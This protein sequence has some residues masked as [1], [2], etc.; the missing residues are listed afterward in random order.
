MRSCITARENA[1]KGI[2]EELQEEEERTKECDDAIA[3]LEAAIPEGKE[4][5]KMREE[6]LAN[7]L[8]IQTRVK[9]RVVLSNSSSLSR[10]SRS[11]ALQRLRSQITGPA[12]IISGSLDDQLKEV[13][14]EVEQIGGSIAELEQ[15]LDKWWYLRSLST[16]TTEYLTMMKA[17]EE[18]SLKKAQF[19]DIPKREK[20]EESLKKAQSDKIPKRSSDS[21]S[22]VPDSIWAKIFKL[23]LDTEYHDY[24]KSTSTTP[25][26][27]LVYVISHVCRSWRSIV[28]DTAELWTM[29][30]TSPLSSWKEH[31]NTLLTLAIQKSR[32]PITV[33]S[34]LSQATCKHSQPASILNGDNL[35]SGKLY[36]L[37]IAMMDDHEAYIKN[38][39]NLQ[40]HQANSLILSASE[41][42]K[43]GYF[44]YTVCAHGFKSV[45]SLTIINEFPTNLQRVYMSGIFPSLTAL[46]FQFKQFPTSSFLLAGYLPSTLQALYIHSDCKSRMPTLEGISLPALHTL[47]ICSNGLE[48]LRQ[49]SMP[50][51]TRLILYGPIDPKERVETVYIGQISTTFTQ[52][53]H[54]GLEGWGAVTQEDDMAGAVSLVRCIPRRTALKCVRFTDCFVDGACLV[55]MG[56]VYSLDDKWTKTL[57]LDHTTGTTREQCEEVRQFV[58]RLEIYV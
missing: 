25:L 32:S 3:D 38:L 50:A 26:R 4:T 11:E 31:E 36:T 43:Y 57:I 51:I 9:E 33:I 28:R 17:K 8:A 15:E 54:L 7:L 29:A 18:E 56:T 14:R 13:R 35:F 49:V 42:L 5:L 34:N 16:A 58:G 10:G 2:E 6:N 55:G 23:V 39:T 37:H 19:D 27:P 21:E 44:F 48:F 53:T 41:P 22:Q 45:T 40:F 24:I 30:Y 52:I 20:E 46:T 1:I 12:S 47:G